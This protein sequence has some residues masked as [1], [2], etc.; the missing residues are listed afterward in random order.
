MLWLIIGY[1]DID[2]VF[3]IDILIDNEFK[4]VGIIYF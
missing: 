2:I 3:I 1:N 4:D